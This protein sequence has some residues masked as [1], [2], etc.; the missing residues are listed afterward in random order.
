VNVV[1]E[2][3]GVEYGSEAVLILFDMCARNLP[4]GMENEFHLYTDQSDRY[5]AGIVVHSLYEPRVEGVKLTLDHLIVGPLDEIAERGELLE[6]DITFYTDGPFPVGAKVIKCLGK[7]PQ[8][9]GGWVKHVWKIGGGTAPVALFDAN[10]SVDERRQNVLAALDRKCGWFEPVAAHSGTAIIVGGGPSLASCL[11]TLRAIKGD[12]FAVNNAPRYLN[13][14]GIGI[15]A[16]VLMDAHE[17]VLK[18]ASADIRMARYYASQCRPDVLEMAGDELIC[19]HAASDCLKG[20]GM[21]EARHIVGGG[22]TTAMRTMVLAYGLG[23]RRFELFGLDSSFAGG[24]HH[25]YEQHEY[26]S[27]LDVTCGERTFQ[28]SPQ[29]VAQAE[30]F[31]ITAWDMIQVGCEI[32]VHGDSLLKEIAMEMIRETDQMEKLYV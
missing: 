18:F 31:K 12:I 16:H 4:S 17:H 28:S 7:K 1:C 25:C 9:L 19:W 2:R 29:M 23:Y 13:N 22:T 3:R 8:D 15:Y 24:R 20:L 26:E 10:V 30:D 5:P 14:R 27:I 6:E 11:L 21:Y 32:S